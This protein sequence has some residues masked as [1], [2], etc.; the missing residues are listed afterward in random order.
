M[1]ISIKIIKLHVL[2]YI[3]DSTELSEPQ[4]FEVFQKS[5]TSTTVTLSW[6]PPNPPN[7]SIVGYIIQYNGKTVQVCSDDTTSEISGLTAGI[8]YEFKVAAVYKTG[9]GPFTKVVS[10]GKLTV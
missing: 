8:E 3:T 4:K 7:G 9:P 10:L 6:E 1:Y 5:V 2:C